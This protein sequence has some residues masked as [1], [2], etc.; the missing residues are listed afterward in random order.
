[1]FI[2][3]EYTKVSVSLFIKKIFSQNIMVKFRI[4]IFVC[5][6]SFLWMT[7]PWKKSFCSLNVWIYKVSVS[8]FTFIVDTFPGMNAMN[9][10]VETLQYKN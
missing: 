1:M 5:C 6:V 9:I 10:F 8:P 4:N 7:T 2:L 3:W